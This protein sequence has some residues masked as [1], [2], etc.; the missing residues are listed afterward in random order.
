MTSDAVKWPR[1]AVFV[2]AVLVCGALVIPFQ[3]R[4]ETPLAAFCADN[5][6]ELQRTNH[7]GGLDPATWASNPNNLARFGLGG[8]G[9][10]DTL[11][12]MVIGPGAPSIKSYWSN[13]NGRVEWRCQGQ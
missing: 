5:A 4:A 13:L 6:V 3:A 9:D 1:R 12:Q 7:E 10:I 2:G 8:A 11:Y